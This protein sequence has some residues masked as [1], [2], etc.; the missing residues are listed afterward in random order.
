[1]VTPYL[2]NCEGRLVVVE[3]VAGSFERH[4]AIITAQGY[5]AVNSSM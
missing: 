2:S 4:P 1:M 5:G 3:I